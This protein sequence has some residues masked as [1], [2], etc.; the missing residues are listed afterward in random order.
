MGGGKVIP[1]LF[2]YEKVGTGFDRKKQVGH[3]D[4]QMVPV[5][6]YL[7]KT[8]IRKGKKIYEFRKAGV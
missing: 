2:P 1:H 7:A 6:H 4:E 8:K 5:C 3:K